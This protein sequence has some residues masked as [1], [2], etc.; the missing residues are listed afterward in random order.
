MTVANFE[1][2]RDYRTQ[3]HFGANDLLKFNDKSNG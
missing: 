3:I 1:F 2:E